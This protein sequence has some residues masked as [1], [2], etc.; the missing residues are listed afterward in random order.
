MLAR[1]GCQVKGLPTYWDESKDFR[2]ATVEKGVDMLKLNYGVYSEVQD[3]VRCD[4]RTGLL[5][6]AGK[7]RAD[8]SRWFG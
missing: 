2:C 1:A 3:G 7:S 4:G 8:D 6:R 5:E